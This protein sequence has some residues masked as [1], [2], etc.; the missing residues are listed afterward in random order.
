MHKHKCLDYLFSGTL[1]CA[2]IAYLYVTIRFFIDA[3]VSYPVFDM[4]NLFS[5]TVQ[6][7]DSNNLFALVVRQLNEHRPIITS[8][9]ILL[10]YLYFGL[11]LQLIKIFHLVSYSALVVLIIWL[12]GHITDG[13]DRSVRNSAKIIVYVCSLFFIL[14]MRQWEV[15]YGYTNVGTIQCFLFY[16]YAVSLYSKRLDRFDPGKGFTSES[17]AAVIFFAAL[18]TASMAFGLLTMPTVC[19][20][21]LLRG[22]RKRES[23]LLAFLIVMFFWV[24][25]IEM[26]ISPAD[27]AEW[28]FH[29]NDLV[30]IIYFALMMLGSLFTVNKLAAL[31]IGA[32]GMATASIAGFILIIKK[33]YERSSV[34]TVSCLMLLSLA[35]AV[36]VGIGRRHLPDDL[37]MASRYSLA[38]AIYWQSLFAVCLYTGLHCFPQKAHTV[39]SFFKIALISV[40][41][42]LFYHQN[43][44]Y[45]FM[46]SRVL[47]NNVAVN[48]LQFGVSDPEKY[49]LIQVVNLDELYSWAKVL[50]DHQ[51]SLYGTQFA[52]LYGKN[53]NGTYSI[54]DDRCTGDV[55]DITYSPV[56]N[57]LTSDSSTVGSKLSGWAKSRQ[58]SMS[59]PSQILLVDQNGFIKGAG[60]F[61]EEGSNLLK[62]PG[63][64][65]IN[66]TEW[67]GFARLNKDTTELYVYALYKKENTICQF[68]T[69]NVPKSGTAHETY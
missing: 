27:K 32:I 62:N 24:Y 8:A 30:R 43:L 61:S 39:L 38:A 44:Q 11:D 35:Y 41:I 19:A 46:K 10:D 57:K 66:S 13:L 65:V 1:L 31:I 67:V 36:M 15:H 5:E 47:K 69:L 54:S 22:S 64:P 6:Y 58:P 51:T 40:I 20:V 45:E 9:V 23:C 18:S 34:I 60:L 7:V 26:N 12:S 16:A 49:L 17:L 25:C 29:P 3:D 42:V 59:P 63:F 55:S 53:I 2:S 48:A 50:K 21:S 52:Q 33:Q 37:A 56:I 14:S 68:F 4:W 28:R